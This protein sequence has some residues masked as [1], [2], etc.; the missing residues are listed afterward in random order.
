VRTTSNIYGDT[1]ASNVVAAV[2]NVVAGGSV[3]TSILEVS[4]N[5][6]GDS[7]HVNR[8]VSASAFYGD[9]SNL[10]NLPSGSPFTM[11]TTGDTISFTGSGKSMVLG[12]LHPNLVSECF[13]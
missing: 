2:G 3:F 10:E 13:C 4:G 1:L 6:F 8:G 5:V 11:S 12:D 9:G 7:I